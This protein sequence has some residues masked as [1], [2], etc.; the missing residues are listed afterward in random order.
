[1]Q[2]G[3]IGGFISDSAVSV[4]KKSVKVYTYEVL[5]LGSIA[6]FC[7]LLFFI[8]LLVYYLK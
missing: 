2:G 4:A 3:C 5:A 6:V 7:Y 1:M 8:L